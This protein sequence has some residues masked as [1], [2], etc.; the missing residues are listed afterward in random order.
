MLEESIGKDS[1][2]QRI[3][4]SRAAVISA[5]LFVS[6]KPLTVETIAEATDSDIVTVEEILEDVLSLFKDDVHGFS[7]HEVAGGW[8]LRTSTLAADAVKRLI[9][10]RGKK[11][12]RAAAE[13]LAVIAYKQPVERAEIESIRGVDALPTLKT[14][15]DGKLIRVVG[16]AETAGTPALYGTTMTFLEKFGLKDLSDLPSGHEL[17][18]L[19]AEP[20]EEEALENE[21]ASQ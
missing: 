12:S 8:Q 10:P 17:E 1:L 7:L 15:L 6:P 2:V 16:R 18:E 5:L 21:S 4:L 19:L 14:L 20:G 3:E 9:P 13:T 11:L